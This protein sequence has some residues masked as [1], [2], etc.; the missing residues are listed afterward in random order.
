MGDLLNTVLR[1]ALTEPSENALAIMRLSL[2][3]WLAVGVAG[4]GEPVARITREMVQAEGGAQLVTMFGGGRAPAR[5]AALVNGT[6]S[7]ALDLDDT[8]FAHIGHPSVAVIPAALAVA[9]QQSLGKAAMLRAALAGCEASVRFGV[10]F[11]RGHYQT[12]FHQTATAG[13]FGATVA[14]TMLLSGDHE[15]MQQALAIVSTRASGLKSQFGTMGKPYN[16]GLAAAN[17]VEAASLAMRGFTSS[18]L[19]VEGPLGFCETHHCDGQVPDTEG[20]LMEAVNH[21]FHACCHGLH[22]ALEALNTLKPLN[23][24]AVT[25]VEIH[26]HPRWMSVCNKPEPTTG[27]EAKFSYRMVTALSLLGR[28]TAD[29]ESFTNELCGNPNVKRLRDKVDV[30]A[31]DTLT[32]TQAHVVINTKAGPQRAEYDI[33]APLNTPERALR[34]RAKVDALLGEAKGEM[35][36]DAVHDNSDALEEI[37]SR[38]G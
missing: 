16:A 14:A 9:E 25:S 17:G 22:A 3:D 15:V 7:H 30:V 36:W 24:E 32:E 11:G 1:H 38:M 6:T 27:L 19:A 8:H 33:A 12:G 20:F 21:K 13:A 28:D 37:T 26:T 10:A 23:P 4:Q 35:I 29:L 2:V 18:D 31:D 5:A 34:I